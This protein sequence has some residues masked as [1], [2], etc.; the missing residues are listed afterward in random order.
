MVPHFFKGFVGVSVVPD[1]TVVRTKHDEGV[2]FQALLFETLDDFSDAP[3]QLYDNITP[4][5]KA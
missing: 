5:T 2:F 1:R 3:V 4:V